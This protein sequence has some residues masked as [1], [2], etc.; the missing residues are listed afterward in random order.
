MK[1]AIIDYGA[2]NI[3]SVST[4][5]ERLG[6]SAHLTMDPKDIEV[7]DKV[8]FP[9]VGHAQN[10][11]HQLKLSGL[12]QLIPALNQ[13]VLGICLGMQLMCSHSE[14]GNTPALGIFDA[15]VQRFAGQPGFKVPHMGWNLISPKPNCSLFDKIAEGG[16][17]YFVH[18]YYVPIMVNTAAMAHYQLP[19]SAALEKDNFFATQ[20]HPEKSGSLG[21]QI[22]HNFL[23]L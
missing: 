21:E 9:G 2:G 1:I 10:A 11:M 7:A 8:I 13:P 6:F 15:P 12:D 5:V 18:S 19:F 22:L 17:V 23:K 4:A 20:F 16:Y 3:A 14:E